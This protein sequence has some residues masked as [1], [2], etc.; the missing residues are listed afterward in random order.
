MTTQGTIYSKSYKW[1]K[2]ADTSSPEAM[3]E[4]MAKLMAPE[5]GA[6]ADA[7]QELLANTPTTPAS[8]VN[9][10]TSSEKE[11]EQNLMAGG[12]GGDVKT[13]VNTQQQNITT[14]VSNITTGII[15]SGGGSSL[16]NRHRRVLPGQFRNA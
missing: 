5:T 11:A 14:A 2:K 3:A 4:A 6:T 12:G 1:Y 13:E 8:N 15:S 7:A 10:A 9:D 16:A